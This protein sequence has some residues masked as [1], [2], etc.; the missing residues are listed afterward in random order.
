MSNIFQ[1]IKFD[2]IQPDAALEPKPDKYHCYLCEYNFDI[3]DCDEHEEGDWENGYYIVHS[4]PSCGDSG[5]EYTMSKE[6]AEEWYKWN[7]KRQSTIR[8]D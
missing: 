7:E 4:C 2:L 6:R 1:D 5:G 8:L 3:V